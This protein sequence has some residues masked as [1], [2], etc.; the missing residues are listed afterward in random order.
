MTCAAPNDL[1]ISRIVISAIVALPPVPRR[2]IVYPSRT[3]VSSLGP[4]AMP[5]RRWVI[6]VGLC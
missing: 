6:E 2:P 5:P 1:R 3:Q 4:L